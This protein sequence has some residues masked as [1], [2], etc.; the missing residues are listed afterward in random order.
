M[1][2]KFAEVWMCGSVGML[3]DETYRQL[4]PYHGTVNRTSVK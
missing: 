2:K 1:H 4:L 3:E